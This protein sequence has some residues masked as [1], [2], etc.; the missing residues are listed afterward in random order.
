MDLPDL[1]DIRWPSG[2]GAESMRGVAATAD[3]RSADGVASRRR[4][5]WVALHPTA[6]R[7]ARDPSATPG[8][9]G[10]S[11]RASAPT[12]GVAWSNRSV[13]ERVPSGGVDQGCKDGVACPALSPVD[14]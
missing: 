4:P 8:S 9:R 12:L 11:D 2:T 10:T 7:T 1:G 14:P 3:E 5:G 6:P 13:G